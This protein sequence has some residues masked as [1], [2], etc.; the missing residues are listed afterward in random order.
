MLHH[1]FRAGNLVV[2]LDAR[3][4]FLADRPLSLTHQ[5]FEVLRLL[6]GRQ[7]QIVPHAAICEALWGHGGTR[8]LKRLGVAM[9]NLRNK[10]DGLAPYAITTVRSRGYGLLPPSHPAAR[11]DSAFAAGPRSR[12]LS[13]VSEP[14]RS[15]RQA[16]VD[17]V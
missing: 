16:L 4:A 7:G 9:S 3:R 12:E 13:D 6:V 5:E 1:L 14:G 15:G 10:L 8:E 11:E 17:A 2:D